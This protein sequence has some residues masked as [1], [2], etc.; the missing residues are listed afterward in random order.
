MVTITDIAA[1]AGVSK[2]TVSYVLN[3]R[4]TAVRISEDTRQR[5]ME[6][7][8]ELGYRR[9]ELARAVTTGKSRM[10]GFWVMESQHEPVAR[11]LAGAM[12]EANLHDYFIKMLGFDNEAN[13]QRI[14]EQC[15][16]WRL[17]GIITIHASP[18]ALDHLHPQIER[19][20]IPMVLVD[21]QGPRTGSIH[22]TSDQIQGVRLAIEHLVSLGHR[23]IAYVTGRAAENELLSHRRAEAYQQVMQ[24]RGLDEHINVVYGN[25]DTAHTEA[26]TR[27]LL[28]LPQDSPL[29]PTAIACWSDLTAMVVIRTATQMGI[30][31][32]EELSVTGF[33][34]LAGAALYNPPLT[35]V[36]QAFEEIGSTAVRRLLNGPNGTP[37]KQKQC[38]EEVLPVRLIV[39]ASTAPVAN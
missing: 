35:T 27:R 31:V 20:E 29:R 22:I 2:A 26:E 3:E 24:E 13:P 15:I 30:R 39:R 1:K 21:C 23:K 7:A 34:D 32:P 11:V 8:T 6:A 9:N 10:L 25:W 14:I 37:V 4:A 33:D 36:S 28:S 16:E 12:K 17:A 5:V 19:F 38:R 18:V